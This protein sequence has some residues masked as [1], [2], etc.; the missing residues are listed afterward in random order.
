MVIAAGVDGRGGGC[1]VVVAMVE[2]SWWQQMVVVAT[3]DGRGSSGG[4]CNY[5]CIEMVDGIAQRE[6]RS[7]HIDAED[8]FL[9][10]ATKEYV[11]VDAPT[12][13]KQISVV[14]YSH[15]DR[16]GPCCM[17]ESN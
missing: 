14:V 2:L 7:R 3:C 13:V 4:S 12:E 8:K 11:D 9:G 15:R 6:A 16:R 1:A 10:K 17:I 5:M